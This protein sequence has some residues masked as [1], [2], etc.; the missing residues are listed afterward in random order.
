MITEV[1]SVVTIKVVAV[2]VVVPWD[3]LH[4]LLVDRRSA[5][6]RRASLEIPS[7]NHFSNNI[8]PASLLSIINNN[9][10]SA[11]RP[12]NNSTNNT[13]RA[14]EAGDLALRR[15]DAPLRLLFIP[16]HSFFDRK[17]RM[18]GEEV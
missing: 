3:P 7:R 13:I 2:A 10:S 4:R 18:P 12:S 6:D 11:S 8:K 1:V 16:R 5:L 14:A 15:L 9:S 17:H